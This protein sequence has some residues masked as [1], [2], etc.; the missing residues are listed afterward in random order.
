MNEINEENVE[1]MQGTDTGG[2]TELSAVDDGTNIEE[3]DVSNDSSQEKETEAVGESISGGDSTEILGQILSELQLN[4]EKMDEMQVYQE[5]RDSNLFLK[6]LSV[7][8]T[9]EGL[10]LLLFLGFVALSVFRLV[11]GIIGCKKR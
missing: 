4:N 10:L 1:E 9:A 5:E 2:P 3:G 6:P 8:T 11:G 7:Y